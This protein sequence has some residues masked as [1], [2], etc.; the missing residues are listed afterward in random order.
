[1]TGAAYAA[2]MPPFA[3]HPVID[4]Q[5]VC[6]VCN[7]SKPV[8]AFYE[9]KKGTGK[10]FAACK[11]CTV[12]Q[13]K[14][15]PRPASYLGEWQ[16]THRDRVRAY[17]RKAYA[18]NPAKTTDRQREKWATD[19]EWRMRKSAQTNIARR[20]RVYASPSEVVTIAEIGQ[21]DGWICQL[22][23]EP[24][25]ASLRAQPALARTHPGYPTLD[26]IQPLSVATDGC[27][28][29]HGDAQCLHGCVGGSGLRSN[30]QLA[31]GRCN[32]QKAAHLPLR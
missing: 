17:N 3:Q 32:K 4:G 15:N 25:D 14:A 16:A 9:V 18:K 6:S 20:G 24:V 21:R 29:Q 23:D 27:R 12:A 30:F 13:Q 28:L 31:H 26:H 22:C 2:L 19:P 7:E 1:V 5:K 8:A 11:V 10:L